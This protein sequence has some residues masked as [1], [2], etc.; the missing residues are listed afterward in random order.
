MRELAADFILAALADPVIVVELDGTIVYVNR[1]LG[2]LL[3]RDALGLIGTP[4]DAL[5]PVESIVRLVG[6]E[7]AFDDGDSGDGVS[8]LFAHRDGSAIATSV[9]ATRH[10]HPEGG[11][12]V[13]LAARDQRQVQQQLAS[14]SREA[15]SERARS[16]DEERRRTTAEAARHDLLRVH[17]KLRE[18][19]EARQKIETELR[20]AQKLEAVGQLA[21]G[22]AHEINTPVQFVGDSVAFLKDSFADLQ[23]L[24]AS[25]EPLA[26][27]PGDPQRDAV[28]FREA[29]DECDLPYLTEHV[30]K[31]FHSAEVGL[32]RIASL[33]RAMKA[34]ARAD[35]RERAFADVN[36]ALRDTITVTRNEHK[37]VATVETDFGDVPE[38]CC[39]IGELNQAFLNIIVNASHAIADDPARKGSEGGVITVRTRRRGDQVEVAISDTGPGI[40]SDVQPRIFDPF[41]TTKEVGKGTGQGLAIAHAIVVEQHGGTITVKTEAGRGTTFVISLPIDDGRRG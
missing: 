37:Y 6:L 13:V 5:L 36:A 12:I 8:V 2:N 31:A 23:R 10:T 19:V 11:T 28:A 20:H 41:F 17:E 24:V 14:S 25:L 29:C 9:T 27:E 21:A 32:A 7:A 34:F 33:V 4:F 35:Q 22:I 18:E 40:P 26:A 38:V 15:A 16:L 3:G 30:P 1:A 39:N